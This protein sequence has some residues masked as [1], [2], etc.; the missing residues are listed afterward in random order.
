[1][2]FGMSTPA[3]TLFHVYLSLLG[4]GS[5]LLVFGGLM[6]GKRLNALTAV[7][8]GSTVATS[9]TGFAF[10]FERLLPSHKVG[11]LSLVVLA[12]AIVARY[13]FR[14]AGAWRGVYVVCASI[15]LYLNVF[16]GVVQAFQK[17]PAL[18]SLAPTQSEAPFL[19]AQVV[20]LVVFVL[21][22]AVT[23]VKFRELPV[24]TA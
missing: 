14:L 13:S 1:M 7:F 17:I 24:Q 8:L 12:I 15:A 23:A 3:F 9:V 20:L 22:A 19:L 10:P 6:A 21:L 18:K 16:V 2:I 11:I 4:M 5:G